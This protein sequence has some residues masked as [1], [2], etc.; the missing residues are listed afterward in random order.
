MNTRKRQQI[1]T[2]TITIAIFEH[3]NKENCTEKMSIIIS[4][5]YQTKT[6]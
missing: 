5:Y 3:K 6:Q 2:C 1:K 4:S